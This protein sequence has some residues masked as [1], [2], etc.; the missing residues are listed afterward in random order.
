[1]LHRANT[2]WLIAAGY[3]IGRWALLDGFKIDARPADIA[4]GSAQ[5]FGGDA[6]IRGAVGGEDAA[7]ATA[8][9][10]GYRQLGDAR[11]GVASDVGGALGCR[12]G[13]ISSTLGHL[14][15]LSPDGSNHRAEACTHIGNALLRPI[16]ECIEET[17]RLRW[18]RRG[19]V[20]GQRCFRAWRLRRGSDAGERKKMERNQARSSASANH[21]T[22]RRAPPRAALR[23][24]LNSHR[25]FRW[26]RSAVP[27]ATL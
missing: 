12:R 11:C 13:C 5:R 3:P 22:I 21:G 16:P 7:L 6:A 19:R 17:L 10:A 8:N 2:F 24:R 25:R 20:C 9:D 14:A 26:S 4:L 18:R 15:G 23:F 1:M 27:N